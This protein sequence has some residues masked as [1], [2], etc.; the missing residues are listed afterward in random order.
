MRTKHRLTPVTRRRPDGTSRNVGWAKRV[1]GR[2]TW[3]CSSAVAPTATAADAYYE[4]HFAQLWHRTPEP[5]PASIDLGALAGYFLDRKARAE[6]SP[7]TVAEYRDAVQEFIDV[8]GD[9]RRPSDLSPADFAKVRLAWDNRFGPDRLAKFVIMI[10]TMFKWGQQPPLRLVAPE[11]GDEFNV[12][13]K[14]AF[15]RDR[16]AQRQAHGLKLFDATELKSLLMAARPTLRAMVLLGL[17]GG[18]GNTDVAELPLSAVDLASGW[19]DYARG[20]TGVDRRFPLWPETAAAVRSVMDLRSERFERWSRCGRRPDPAVLP[21]LFV[22]RQ[23]RPYAEDGTGRGGD[24]RPAH[25]DR[26]AAEFRR[27]CAAAGLAR[28]GRGFYSLRRTH[29]T[30]AD[31]AGDQRAAAL[32]M[33]HEVGDV[34]GLYVQRIDDARLRRVTDHVRA[35]VLEDER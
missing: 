31:G 2:P 25:K 22:T 27:A 16:A 35:A 13:T 4:A 34:A 17:N 28:V 14:L 24:P 12:P 15:K 9:E 29:R 7:R 3:I 26:V 11:Y 19:V 33:G 1:N 21:L 5:E 30:L 8:V 23:G 6:L 10:R 32:I 18:L 20:K